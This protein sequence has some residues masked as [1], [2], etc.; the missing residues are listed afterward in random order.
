MRDGVYVSI[1]VVRN[2]EAVLS[3]ERT[4]DV[5]PDEMRSKKE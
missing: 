1:F 2:A 3:S 4:I 5:K